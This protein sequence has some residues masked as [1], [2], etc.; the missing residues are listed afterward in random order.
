MLNHAR[1]VEIKR[2]W[3]HGAARVAMMD[4][5]IAS[6]C[7]IHCGAYA[8]LTRGEAGACATCL[9]IESRALG[10]PYTRVD[11]PPA[12]KAAAAPSRGNW[13]EFVPIDC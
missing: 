11:A 9:R 12:G 10:L 7:C 3:R 13:R 2:G 8:N 6:G 4:M 5:R 1:M